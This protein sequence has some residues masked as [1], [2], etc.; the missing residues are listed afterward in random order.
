LGFYFNNKAQIPIEIIRSFEN[1]FDKKTKFILFVNFPPPI[2]EIGSNVEIVMIGDSQTKTYY[3][4]KEIVE[5]YRFTRAFR[6]FHFIF[7][8]TVIGFVRHLGFVPKRFLP[9]LLGLYPVLVIRFFYYLNFLK[10]NN[11]EKC[12]LTDTTDVIFQNDLFAKLPFKDTVVFEEKRE[13]KIRKEPYNFSWITKLYSKK[14]FFNELA[15]QTICCAGTIF[16]GSKKSSNA[17]L[18]VMTLNCLSKKM[19]DSFSGKINS[20]LEFSFQNPYA[21]SDQGVFNKI[22]FLR[23]IPLIKKRNG[24]VI[25]TIGSESRENIDFDGKFIIKRGDN[26]VPSVIHQYNRHPDLLEF[27]KRKYGS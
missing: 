16:L 23:Q 1:C 14:Q 4:V 9:I 2:T 22:I 20:G 25:F 6:F 21:P 13:I 27:V 18:K 11:F 26:V 24:D 3:Y 5:K 12:L 15:N 8:A 19:A 17:F 7:R 10:E